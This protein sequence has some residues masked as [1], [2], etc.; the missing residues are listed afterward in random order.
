[1]LD[2]CIRQVAENNGRTVCGF[3]H[4]NVSATSRDLLDSFVNTQLFLDIV[5]LHAFRFGFAEFD[6][7]TEQF[8]FDVLRFSQ[9]GIQLIL[10]RRFFQPGFNEVDGFSGSILRVQDTFCE[11]I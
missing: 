9:R 7:L 11:K 3:D 6:F 4:M 5:E 10:N 2:F 8:L 1:M